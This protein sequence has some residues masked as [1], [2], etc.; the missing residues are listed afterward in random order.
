MEV[1]SRKLR[2]QGNFTFQFEYEYGTLAPRQ[3]GR[4]GPSS[5]RTGTMIRFLNEVGL[6]SKADVTEL[7]EQELL[8]NT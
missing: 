8:A 4:V 7:G 2:T 1:A 6:L 3:T 5:P